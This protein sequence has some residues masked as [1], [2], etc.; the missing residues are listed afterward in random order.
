MDGRTGT[1]AMLRA[2]NEAGFSSTYLNRRDAY[3]KLDEAACDF[4]R[5]AFCLTNT[6][7]IITVAGRQAYDLPPDF[8]EPL[9]K[10]GDGRFFGA[11][12]DSAGDRS[13]P[14]LTS[15][16]KIRLASLDSADV[17]GSFC[18]MDKQTRPVLVEGSATGAGAEA[19]GE[20]AL[21][22]TSASFTGTVNKRDVIHKVT[23]GDDGVVLSVSGVSDLLT[24]IF[25]SSG[26]PVGWTAG[27]S[28]SI[29]PMS[30]NSILL[31]A[32]SASGGGIFVLDYY[33]LPAPVF[34][35]F[36][37][38]RFDP[39]CCRA[40]CK[41]GAALFLD[42]KKEWKAAKG[43]HNEFAREIRQARIETGRKNILRTGRY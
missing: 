17:P 8:L 18:I 41:E 26:E 19:N 28:Y 13:F 6:V 10:G 22:D 15:F 37:F 4:A 39:K 5:R 21:T 33:C 29:L 9:V 7:E 40:I 23:D 2:L 16:E 38:W 3:E 25:N 32:P 14:V 43:L 20:S 11:Y 12:E 35:E 1:R 36:S 42:E 30:R 24:A 34:S 27:D 31:D